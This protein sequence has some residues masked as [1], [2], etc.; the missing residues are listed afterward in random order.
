MNEL[1]IEFNI[2]LLFYKIYF[3]L[4]WKILNLWISQNK[5]LHYQNVKIFK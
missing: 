2:I 4:K 3:I 5:Y 1:S